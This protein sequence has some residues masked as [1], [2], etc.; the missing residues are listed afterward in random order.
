MRFTEQQIRRVAEHLLSALL[1]RGGATLKAER[2]VV[3]ARI[4][5]IVRGNLVA[6]EDLDCEARQLLEAHL[7]GAPPGVDRQKLFLMIKK[8]LAEERGVPL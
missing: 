6:E 2:G 4:E 5:D 8:R 7:R 3:L 1:E